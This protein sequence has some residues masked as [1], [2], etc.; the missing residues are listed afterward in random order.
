M[1]A[2][3]A[4]SVERL[5]QDYAEA[6]RRVELAGQ[7]QAEAAQQLGISGSGLRSRVQRGRAMLRRQMQ[8]EC[9]LHFDARDRLVDCTPRSACC[10]H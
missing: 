1:G 3:L 10:S 2:W 7:S 9:E 6:L 4:T 8:R 5:P